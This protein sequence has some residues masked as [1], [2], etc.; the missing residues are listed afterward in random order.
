MFYT[1][2]KEVGY[3]KV[4]GAK[5]YWRN[6]ILN[7]HTYVSVR[8]HS[9]ISTCKRNLPLNMNLNS[10]FPLARKREFTS[11]FFASVCFLQVYGFSPIIPKIIHGS[12]CCCEIIEL[13]VFYHSAYTF[14]ISM[15]CINTAIRANI[16]LIIHVHVYCVGTIH[17]IV[18]KVNAKKTANSERG[19]R[20]GRL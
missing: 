20:E 18:C 12:H 9:R 11:P 8:K 5:S 6:D 2:K 17:R 1:V 3:W 7:P 19:C 15:R 14:I 4:Y 13:C 10:K 16:Y